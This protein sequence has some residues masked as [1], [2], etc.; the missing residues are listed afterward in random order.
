VTR[1]LRVGIVGSGVMGETHLAAWV[2]EG[3][4]VKI[5]SQDAGRASALAERFEAGFARSVDELLAD[6]EIVDIC[7]P[8]DHHL[9]ATV[10]A[11]AAGCHVICEKPIARTL[12]DAQEMI[13]TC[14]E[15]GVRLFVAQVVRYFPHYALARQAVVDGAIGAPAVIRLKRATA[16]PRQSPDHWL[17]D[18][19]RSGGLILDFMIHDFDFARWLA[20]EVVSVH[21]RSAGVERPGLGIEHAVAILTHATGAISLVSGSWGYSPPVFRTSFEISG[22]LGL[23]EH[24]T[25]ASPPVVAYLH[26]GAPGETQ[27]V[28]LPESPLAEDPYRLELRDF[29]RA[30]SDGSPTRVDAS[31]GLEALRIA[32]AADESA[33]T[34]LPVSIPSQGGS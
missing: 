28:S 26:A 10:A 8:T 16:R 33:R 17:F 15:A 5:F 11:A 20:G 19:A 21:C 22:S 6:S 4:P 25:A 14:S 24:D 32:L 27:P 9:E 7:T 1:P 13:A 3:V 23:I 29:H 31:D 12:S 18:R 30:I 34:G 2:A